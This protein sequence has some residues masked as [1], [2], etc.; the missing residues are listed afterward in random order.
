MRYNVV[1]IHMVAEHSSESPLD[2]ATWTVDDRTTQAFKLLGSE[3]RLA[4]LLALWEALDSVPILSEQAES[5]LSF[6]E[7]RKRVGM[8]DPGQFRYHLEK[9]VGEFV[10]STEDGYTLTQFAVTCL[11]PVVAGTMMDHETFD[12]EPSDWACPRCGSAMVI[13]YSDRILTER[14][15]NCAGVWQTSDD[16]PGV[17]NKM[18]RPPAGLA[19]RTPQEFRRH[20]YTYDRHRWMSM[21]EGVCPGCSGS[22]TVAVHVCDDHDTAGETVCESCGTIYEI[23][24]VS[25]CC[26][27]KLTQ[28]V[29]AYAPIFPEMAVKA[30]YFEH[31]KDVEAL[32]DE[33][34]WGILGDSIAG[35]DVKDEEPLEFTVTVELGGNRLAVTLDDDARVFD[36]IE[37]T[38]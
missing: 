29:P 25:K 3:I 18:Y 1:V 15:T 16:P 14:C 34:A 21:M 17:V 11:Q 6:S 10:D 8:R 22:V 30:F 28:R 26:V 27:C 19:H 24:P 32:L 35:I 31:G 4:I 5:A 37:S 20:G 38:C 2:T 23:Q 7:L 13:D 33:N 12:S 36:V 9:L